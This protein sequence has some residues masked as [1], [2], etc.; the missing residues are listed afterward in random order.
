[1]S[2]NYARE[3]QNILTDFLEALS[4]EPE[5]DPVFLARV[6]A[7]VESGDLASRTSVGRAIRDVEERF[8]ETGH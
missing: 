8:D 5:L 7:M 6:K 2:S 4:E 3:T 1:M